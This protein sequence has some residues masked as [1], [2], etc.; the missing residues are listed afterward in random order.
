MAI[1]ITGGSVPP[2]NSNQAE[3]TGTESVASAVQKS[4][5]SSNGVTPSPTGDSFVI[6]PQAEKL[7]VI[8]LAVN[9]QPDVDDAR[10]ESLKTAIDSGQYDINP[11][12][13]AEKLIALE[14]Q[15]VA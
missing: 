11:L 10:I 14:A 5:V 7:H 13:V 4:G 15:F 8:E 3:K 2:T 9:A 12:Q 6:S 1:E